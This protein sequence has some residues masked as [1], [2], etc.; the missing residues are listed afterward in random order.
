M[1]RYLDLKK[2]FEQNRDYKFAK[3]NS[4]YMRGKFKFYGLRASDRR[5]GYKELIQSDK[6][7]GEIDWKLLD[8][9]ISDEYR[10]FKYFV[11]DYLI[12]MEEYLTIS[13]LD[14]IKSYCLVEPH[15]DTIDIFAKIVGNIVYQ[16]NNWRSLMTSWAKDE[17][18]WIRRISIIHQLKYKENTDKELLRDTILLNVGTEEF[19][20]NKAIGWALREYSKTNPLWVKSFILDHSDKLNSLS[21]REA[22]KY[23]KRLP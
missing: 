4:N 2:Y 5:V 6:N 12:N 3:W 22:S 21:I 8:K 14:K 1:D 11:T 16:T 23:I 13:D 17:N 10:E 9:C 15:W 20:I 18:F 7:D 19:F